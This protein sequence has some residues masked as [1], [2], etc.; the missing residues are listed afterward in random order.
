MRSTV[1]HISVRVPWHDSGWDGTVCAD[2]SRNS[3]CMLLPSIGSTRDD[4][5]EQRLAGRLLHEVKAPWP[6]CVKER[7]N[8]L[9]PHDLPVTKRHPYEWNKALAGLS[10]HTVTLPAWSVHATPYYWMMVENAASLVSDER[11]AE[12][13]AGLESDA[14]R[15]LGFDPKKQTWILHGDNQKALIEAFFRNVRPSRS[16]VFFYLRHAPFDDT[17]RLLVGAALVDDVELPGRWPTRSAVEFPNHMWE[18]TVRHTLRP[19][20]T[21]GILLPMQHLASLAEAGHD[22]TSALAQAPQQNREFSYVTEHVPADT[23]VAALMSLKAAAKACAD[24]G[25]PV[26]QQSLRWVDTQLDLAWR[27]RGAAPGLPA[28]LG[29][30]GFPYPAESAR[31]IIAATGEGDDPWDTLQSGM[32]GVGPG[33]L[34]TDERR[35]AWKRLPPERR[36]ALR[37][38]AR[39][40]LTRDHLSAVLEGH[41]G[42]PLSLEDL[43]HDPYRLVT[44]TID[45]DDP[46]PFDVIDRGCYAPSDTLD[47]SPLPA[48]VAF[49]DPADYRR[50]EAMIAEELRLAARDGHTL[51]PVPVALARIADR[52]L[53]RSVEL[54]AELLAERGIHPD[55]GCFD[56][57]ANETWPVIVRTELA[58]GSGAYKL[59]SLLKTRETVRDLPRR[60]RT[61]PRHS[62]PA[63]LSVGLR[64]VL[65]DL[66]FGGGEKRAEQEKLAA[67]TE[68][69]ESRFTILNGPAGTGK[70]TLIRALVARPEIRDGGVLLLA[71]T[72]KARV[73]LS[74]KAGYEAQTIAQFL[75]RTERFDTVTTRYTITSNHADRA[76][77]GLVV[78]DEASML[79]ETMMAAL[80]DALEL[81]ERLI[82]VGDPRQLPPIGDGR[83]FV[84]LDRAAQQSVAEQ[85]PRIAPGWAAL[86]V[87][88]R[89]RGMTRDDLLLADW[90]SDDA[91]SEE[92]ERVWDRLRDG[93]PMDSLRAV[94]WAGRRPEEV[95]DQV[96]EEELGVRRDDGGRT[97]AASYGVSVGAEDPYSH[98]VDRIEGWQVLSPLRNFAAGTTRLNRHLKQ[99]YRGV[100]LHRAEQAASARSVPKPLGPERVVVG[101]KVVNIRNRKSAD[102]WA[103][104]EGRG[105]GYLANG[106]IGV[107]VGQLRTPKMMSPPRQTQVEYSSQRGRRFAA[108]N[109]DGESDAAVELAWALTVHKAQGSE[110]DV[111]IVMLPA[112]VARVSR[113][114]LYTALTRHTTRVVVCHE[115][116]LEELRRWRH[117]TRSD[118]GRR[119]TDLAASPDPVVATTLTTGPSRESKSGELRFR[120]RRGVAV[121]SKNELIIARILDDLVPGNWEYEKEL[122]SP[123]GRSAR[124]DFT[125]TA[126]GGR[127]VYWEHLGMLDDPE[128]AAKWERKRAWY[129]AYG[130]TEDGGQRGILFTTDDRDGIDE[131]MWE[132]QV[133]G[134]LFPSI[135]VDETGGVAENDNAVDDLSVVPEETDTETEEPQSR[136]RRVVD[137]VNSTVGGVLNRVPR[138]RGTKK[139]SSTGQDDS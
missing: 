2:P 111:V 21:G 39:F 81:P 32:Y 106:E 84:D 90:F 123:D 79:T 129:T 122:L 11:I 86:T 18:T 99:T 69:Y 35:R 74:R 34:F 80:F 72:G 132:R 17:E 73:Q 105:Q 6:P 41:T 19:D 77:Y 29:Y 126:P 59:R 130:I 23:A 20:D 112:R 139:P 83:P 12:Y 60:L 116:S 49:D 134:V 137:R 91:I 61:R 104:G 43:L 24:L 100:D 45:D 109:G 56:D 7:V 115:A 133:A 66:G 118:T 25:H 27:D 48:E 15:A 108:T 28:V 50:I 54:T 8:F 33:T 26:P 63:D 125:I 46:I 47:H 103:P 102:F 93:I 5:Y 135:L 95:L 117:A 53:V 127:T 113:E 3:A 107:V 1:Q 13:R 22:V 68:M 14:N 136:R 38:L 51:L 71:P 37:L 10:R 75:A 92:A 82:L 120:T 131:L 36:K 76:S 96:L 52:N 89:Q 9:S 88:H 97:F 85:W 55:S 138:R 42:V 124:P 110:F 114:M 67:L 64:K 101:D 16:L 44:H 40:D 70:T 119:L 62:A 94:H 87:Q 128:Y 121:R 58:D 65:D 31:S 57:D 98:V 78:I 30:L 4:A